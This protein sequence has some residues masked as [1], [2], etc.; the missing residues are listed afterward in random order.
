MKIAVYPGSFDPITNGHLNIIERTI[1][2][3]SISGASLLFIKASCDSCS[4]SEM[5][6]I[7]LIIIFALFFLTKSVNKPEN[8]ITLTFSKSLVASF[9][10]SVLSCAENKV[11]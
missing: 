9:I 3:V 8:D 10:I 6:L 1:K 2:I 11:D 7:P 5:A 4:K